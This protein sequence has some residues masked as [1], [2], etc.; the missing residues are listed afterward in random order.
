M[1][2][3]AGVESMPT[4]LEGNQRIVGPTVD[5]GP[6]EYTPTMFRDTFEALP[7]AWAACRFALTPK[8]TSK[9]PA[10]VNAGTP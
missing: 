2:V 5:P 3:N 4:D 7:T 1:G 9:R 6:C 10:L 8:V